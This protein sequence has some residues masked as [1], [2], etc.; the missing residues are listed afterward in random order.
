[1]YLAEFCAIR[2]IA[3]VT[4]TAPPTTTAA[5]AAAARGQQAVFHYRVDDPSPSCGFAAVTLRFAQGERVVRTVAL[6]YR[7]TN[8]DLKAAVNVHLPR[9]AYTF[10]VLAVDAAGNVAGSTGTATLVLR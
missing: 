9:G 2:T 4:D 8:Q 3:Q 10:T 6:G 7:P 1:V 5:P